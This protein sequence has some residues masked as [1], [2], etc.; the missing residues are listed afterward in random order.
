MSSSSAPNNAELAW[1]EAAAGYDR[2]FGPRF[3]PY[4]GAVIGALV[5]RARELPSG[6]IVVPCA[7]PG[8]ELGPLARAFPERLIAGSDLSREMV[9]LAQAR[10]SRL[11]NVFVGKGDAL[12]LK[13]PASG[14][15]ALL[16]AF[17]LQLLPEPSKA[18][19]SWV[20]LLV[21]DGLS[22]VLFWPSVGETNGPFHVLHELLAKAGVRGSA[23][24][25][26]LVPTVEALGARVLA[27]QRLAFE[28]EHE[29]A[30]VLWKALAHS[31]PLRTLGLTRGQRL[32]DQ[33]GADFERELP[34]GR[35]VHAPP[36]RLL[37]IRS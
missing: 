19:T 7:G 24:D 18:L 26:A 32:I 3:A 34:R 33:L 16:S 10:N 4:L 9:R 29:G 28:M 12:A 11:G 6:A 30:A 17:G 23:W 14:A 2:Y 37:L 35:L 8:R 21:P 22:A 25:E 20:N 15:A 36:A 5:S 31:G 13:A 27:D 1:D